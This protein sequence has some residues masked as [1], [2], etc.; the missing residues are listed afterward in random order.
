MNLVRLL[1]GIELA[2]SALPLSVVVYGLLLLDAR[3]KGGQAQAD[4]QL[5]I[6]TVAAA[7]VLVSTV[8][9]ATGLRDFLHVMLT[10]DDFG[11]RIK[12]ALPPV[13]VGG[14]GVVGTALMLFPQT[15]AREFPKAKRLTVGMIALGSGVAVPPALAGLIAMIL[16]WP[17]WD[18]VAG[19]LATTI[20]VLAIFGVSFVVLGKLSGIVK[21][22]SSPAGSPPGQAPGPGQ[23]MPG[24]AYPGQAYPGQA[25][26]GAPMPGQAPAGAPM[27]GQA[28]G[29]SPMPGPGQAFP[30]QPPS[31]GGPGGWPQS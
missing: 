16:D 8:L 31:P 3:R 5:G 20:D 11:D 28:P 19:S 24:Q 7:L 6:K 21:P 9:L 30:G 25:P 12:V 29:A 27:P 26:A 18:K 23:A 13:L 10:F 1:P 14:L 4:D 15:N 17:S 22:T 2:W